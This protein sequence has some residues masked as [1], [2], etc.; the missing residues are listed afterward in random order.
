MRISNDFYDGLKDV[1][2]LFLAAGP[3]YTFPYLYDESQEVA[4]A[5]KAACTPEFYV[6]DKS[7]KLLY[8]GQFDDAR[9]SNGVPASGALSPSS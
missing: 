6:F 8:H 5:Y 1:I 2:D 3:G 9:P 4:K 7:L